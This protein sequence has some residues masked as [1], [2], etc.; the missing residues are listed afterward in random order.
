MSSIFTVSAANIID[1]NNFEVTFK[2]G[3]AEH[4]NEMIELFNQFTIHADE[5]YICPVAA[6]PIEEAPVEP[7]VE[8]IE[9]YPRVSFSA[10]NI[11][12]GTVTIHVAHNSN[13][14]YGARFQMYYVGSCPETYQGVD[15]SKYYV[16]IDIITKG[17]VTTRSSYYVLKSHADEIVYHL[18]DHN[19]VALARIKDA[20]QSIKLS[21]VDNFNKL[22]MGGVPKYYARIGDMMVRLGHINEYLATMPVQ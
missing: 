8:L 12:D 1:N 9:E 20:Q 3:N 17:N 15:I 14:E 2:P 5:V 6:S 21:T 13:S 22:Y 11:A 10:H 19:D 16:K 4:A 7:A 18:I